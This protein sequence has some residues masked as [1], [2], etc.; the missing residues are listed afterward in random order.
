VYPYKLSSRATFPVWRPL[1]CAVVSTITVAVVRAGRGCNPAATA[2][3]GQ[4][5]NAYIFVSNA[6]TFYWGNYF[7]VLTKFCDKALKN[8]VVAGFQ[9][10]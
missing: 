7:Y 5:T 3:D 10:A 1:H 4:Y 9:D 8:A 2:R 6:R